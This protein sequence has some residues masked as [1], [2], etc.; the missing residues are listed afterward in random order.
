LP[1]FCV[2]RITDPLM[3]EEILAR[4]EAD[5]VSMPRANIAAQEFANKAR[6]GRLDEIRH[7]I[8]V[9][10]GCIGRAS[11]GLPLTCALNPSVGQEAES[12]ITAAAVR[13]RVLVIGGE[14]AGMEAARVAA[15]RGHRVTLYEQQ[16]QL[17]GQLL[18]AAKAPGRDEMAEPVRYYTRQFKLLGVRVCLGTTVDDALVRA[19]SPDAVIVAT[20]AL[21]AFPCID[22]LEE[23]KAE[24][25]HTVLA[26][27]VLAGSA[28]A[29][30]DTVI[31]LA[32]DQGMDG[33]STVDFL[34]ERGK[35]VEVHTPYPTVGAAVEMMT[36]AVIIGR[37]LRK[38]VKRTVMTAINAI[39]DGVVF[40]FTPPHGPEW[41]LE[42]V[43]TLVLAA[44]SRSNDTL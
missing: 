19:E 3:A 27:D 34:A 26:R 41:P 14:I 8:G 5:M 6:E 33:L 9:N 44:A 42:R 7:C 40:A 10:E 2:G 15:I 20:G 38:H 32:T 22:G 12:A 28:T 37:L 18:I 30:G 43:D 39:R 17:G 4:N 36:Q 16:V 24:G 11:I 31:V 29:V 1:V 25:V 23:G 35:Q 21:P 13:K